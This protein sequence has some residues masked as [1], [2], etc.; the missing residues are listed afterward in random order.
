MSCALFRPLANST[1]GICWLL[2]NTDV[3]VPLSH[4]ADIIVA[5]KQDAAALG[6]NACV[7][8]HVG[9]GNFHENITYDSTK[10]EEYEKAKKAVKSMVQRAIDMEGTCTGEHGIGFGKKEALQQEVGNATI[11][12]M[13]CSLLS[14]SFRINDYLPS[15]GQMTFAN[16]VFYVENSQGN[17]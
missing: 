7:K 12:F 15:V 16:Y 9:D 17:F 8:G 3:A 5:S 2:G 4:L 11:S 10:P 6:L 1:N 14:P 13:V